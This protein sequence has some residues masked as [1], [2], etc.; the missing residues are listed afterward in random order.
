MILPSPNIQLLITR[1]IQLLWYIQ[2]VIK[3]FL[4]HFQA[5]PQVQFQLTPQALFSLPPLANGSS[6]SEY[7]MAPSQS[8]P[9][10][11]SVRRVAGYFVILTSLPPRSPWMKA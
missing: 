11:L 1:Q 8:T 10:L 7:S 5:S 2:C 4:F 9:R 6:R 3:I